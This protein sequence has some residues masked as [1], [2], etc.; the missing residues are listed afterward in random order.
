MKTNCYWQVTG[1]NKVITDITIDFT[2][3]DEI[4]HKLTVEKVFKNC[5]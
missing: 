1:D 2:H 3:S 5:L 4:K